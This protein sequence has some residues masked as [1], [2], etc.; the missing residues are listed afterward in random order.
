MDLRS[1]NLALVQSGLVLSERA[2]K[3]PPCRCYCVSLGSLYTCTSVVESSWQSTL[4]HQTTSESTMLGLSHVPRSSKLSDFRRQ[5]IVCI[6]HH[7]CSYRCHDA[8]HLDEIG[9]N[10]KAITYTLTRHR[11]RSQMMKQSKAYNSILAQDDLLRKSLN[12]NSW[13]RVSR[14]ELLRNDGHC[15]V[16]WCK[17]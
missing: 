9:K 5:F 7:K 17:K 8:G 3:V 2:R 15:L 11:I 4:E 6:E 12:G 13:Q 1:H 16:P 10:E 14:H